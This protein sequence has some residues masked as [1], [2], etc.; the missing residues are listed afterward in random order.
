MTFSSGIAVFPLKKRNSCALDHHS[1]QAARNGFIAYVIKEG[2][3]YQ[4]MQ[5]Q[6]IRLRGAK[7]GR[8]IEVGFLQIYAYSS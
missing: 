1:W 6:H 4:R 7:E 2:T 3:R 5:Q 8:D